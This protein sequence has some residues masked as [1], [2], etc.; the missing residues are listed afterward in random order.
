MFD[1]DSW[2]E[3][4]NAIRTN[5]LRT[6]LT[7]SGVFWG[8][9]ILIIMLGFGTGLKNGVL[10]NMTGY[11]S[12]GYYIW[13]SRTSIPY[14]GLKPG[15]RIKLNNSDTEALR[16]GVDEIAYLLPRIRLGGYRR[17]NDIGYDTRISEA[18]VMGDLPELKN[19]LPMDIDTGRFINRLDIEQKRKVI[20]IG[21][22][23]YADLFPDGRNPVG[24]SI[25]LRQISFTVIGIF[26]PVRY[27]D[28]EER[29]SSTAFIPFTTHQ[30]VFNLN[31]KVNYYGLVPKDGVPSKIMGEKAK[32]LLAERHRVSPVDARAFGSWNSEEEFLRLKNLFAGISYLIWTVGLAT[33][34]AGLLGVSNIMLI[35]IKERTK[36]FG[37]RKAL[38]ATP[39]S[40]IFLITQ[41]TLLLTSIAGY[42]GLTAGILTLQLIDT[43]I[44][45][46]SAEGS[47]PNMFDTPTI[48][49]KIALI[50]LAVLV[51]SGLI[52]AIIPARQAVRINPV[53]AL[54]AE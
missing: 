9:Y 14:Q 40:I 41:E 34:F 8:I 52:A 31:N 48:E 46:T 17:R 47:A 26:K 30:K 29:L 37:I 22:K 16:K 23:I 21:E 4:F 20:V 51:F 10:K 11:A 28:N 50:A 6:L 32:Q 2:Q 27:A 18:E 25:T 7:M 19:I 24:A 3:I 36:E 12:N 49:P 15:R 39:K 13:G 43:L 45:K 42:L 44:K 53:E 5:R 54:R 38:G 1:A 35:V 33:L